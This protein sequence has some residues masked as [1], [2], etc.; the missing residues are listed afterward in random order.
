MVNK[1]EEKMMVNLAKM[2]KLID[3]MTDLVA[4]DMMKKMMEAHSDVGGHH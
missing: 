2:A 1:L 4:T 3:I